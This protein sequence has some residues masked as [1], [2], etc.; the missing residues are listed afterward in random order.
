MYYYAR[1]DHILLNYLSAKKKY[2]NL[3]QE[4]IYKKET[5]FWLKN[6]ETQNKT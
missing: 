5:S 4:N 1:I 6:F 3:Y 2:K